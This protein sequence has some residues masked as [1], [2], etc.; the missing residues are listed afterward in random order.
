M[1]TYEFNIHIENVYH[2]EVDSTDGL[3]TVVNKLMN[4]FIEGKL[5]LDEPSLVS[6]EFWEAKAGYQVGEIDGWGNEWH[7]GE[8]N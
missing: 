8:E 5:A 3:E 7:I 6:A 4:D 1:T 2:V